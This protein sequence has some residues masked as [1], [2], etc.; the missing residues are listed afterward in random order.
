VFTVH[1]HTQGFRL[2]SDGGLGPGFTLGNGLVGYIDH[3]GFAL[4]VKVGQLAHD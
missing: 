2:H 4:I 3:P 1:D